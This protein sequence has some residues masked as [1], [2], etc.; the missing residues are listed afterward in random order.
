MQRMRNNNLEI[1][2]AGSFL[3]PAVT[4]DAL[5]QNDY[6]TVRFLSSFSSYF[7][8]EL[9]SRGSPIGQW[10]NPNITTQIS[11]KSRNLDGYSWHPACRGFNPESRT[12][13]PETSPSNKGDPGSRKNLLRTRFLFKILPLQESHIDK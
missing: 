13:N 6:D 11:L 1:R 2:I 8:S 12:Q 3:S 9:L 4:C 7:F 5:Y 10:F